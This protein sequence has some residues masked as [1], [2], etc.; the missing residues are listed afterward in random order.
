LGEIKDSFDHPGGDKLI[1]LDASASSYGLKQ[2][3][4]MQS[5]WFPGCIH[6]LHF[7]GPEQDLED[8]RADNAIHSKRMVCLK[9]THGGIRHLSKNPIRLTNFAMIQAWQTFLREQQNIAWHAQVCQVKGAHK[10]RCRS[11]G[12]GLSNGW[13]PGGNGNLGWD[14]HPPLNRSGQ[15]TILKHR[16]QP[17]ILLSKNSPWLRS[18]WAG[19]RDACLIVIG[20]F[21]SK[22]SAV[23]AVPMT[24]C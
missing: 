13:C 1:D 24:L 20:V 9:F 7:F 21:E 17:S 10:W 18:H 6:K 11:G 15:E 19:F 23:L 12:L 5:T 14:M 4:R 22:G 2:V 3:D 16:R 8:F